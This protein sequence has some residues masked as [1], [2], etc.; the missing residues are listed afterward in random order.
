M[1]IFRRKKPKTSGNS[2]ID[3][4]VDTKGGEGHKHQ[5]E[6]QAL[7][8]CEQLMASSRELD[9]T[10]KEYRQ[11][12][13]Y[14]NDIQKLE[15]LPEEEMNAI[16]ETAGNIVGLNKMREELSHKE[17]RMSD[18]QFAQLEQLEDEIPD[19]ILRL[20]A[21]ESYQSMVRRDMDNL[22]GEKSEWNYYR[23]SITREQKILKVVLWV[24]LAVFL[25]GFSGLLYVKY[26]LYRDTTLYLMIFLFGAAV[27]SGFCIL[28]IQNN[29]S[30]FQRAQASI[31]RAIT[32]SNQMKAKYVNVTNAVDYACEKFHVRNSMELGYLWDQYLE[33][34]K[35]RE[36]A[37]RANDDLE[38]FS[39]KLVRELRN[40]QFHD[41]SIWVSQAVALVDKKE[42]VE[43]K[44]YLIVRRQ[45]LRSRI[46]KQ[47]EDIQESRKQ[48]SDLLKEHQEYRQEILDVLRSIDQ[49][50]GT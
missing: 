27:V 40:Y 34:V 8:F 39:R 30:E 49:I 19:D 22:E 45:K 44:H 17:R 43:V 20:Q 11:V 15:D 3:P 48:L 31:N 16:K 28:R 24:V 10:K 32:I 1:G 18:A 7:D 36:T 9:E 35:E 5:V 46:E 13:D 25:L 23:E 50:C 12:M 41:A 6:H 33:M 47:V 21:N 26:G 42:M 29:Q 2:Y 38:Y 14:L 37:T 4:Y